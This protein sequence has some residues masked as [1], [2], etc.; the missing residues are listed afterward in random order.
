MPCWQR[1]CITLPWSP[2]PCSRVDYITGS[3][4]A[5]LRVAS[6]LPAPLGPNP[7]FTPSARVRS[8]GENNVMLADV[9]SKPQ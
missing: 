2:G 6:L 5:T 8:R 3:A 4:V 9:M 7:P 1:A